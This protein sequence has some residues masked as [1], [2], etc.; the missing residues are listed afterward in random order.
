MTIELPKDGEDEPP[1][2]DD[3]GFEG[4]CPFCHHREGPFRLIGNRYWFCSAHALMWIGGT[5]ESAE[6]SA[7]DARETRQRRARSTAIHPSQ[8]WRPPAV[9]AA[10]RQRMSPEAF[11]RLWPTETQRSMLIEW[12]SVDDE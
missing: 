9:M 11:E 12:P 4:F 6:E 8:A 7:D 3:A 1:G 10:F 2:N 5:E